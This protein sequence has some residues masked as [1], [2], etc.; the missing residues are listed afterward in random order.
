MWLGRTVRLIVLL[1]PIAAGHA[2]GVEPKIVIASDAIAPEDRGMLDEGIERTRN[3][4]SQ[5]GIF[6]RSDLYLHLASEVTAPRTPMIGRYDAA[7]SRVDL[8][9]FDSIR[10]RGEI[11]RTPW[12]ESLYI[13]FVVHELAHGF[14]DQHFGQD[15]ATLLAHEYLA[16]VAQLSSLPKG[17]RGDILRRYGLQGFQ[18]PKA[19]S[20]LY[21]QL[22]PCAFGVKAYLHFD[23]QRDKRGFLQHLLDGRTPLSVDTQEWW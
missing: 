16:Y 11:F 12:D 8:L 20:V 15:A 17:Q 2:N 19:M 13:S 3:F 14:A 18:N 22:D 7:R 4:F 5:Y 21:Y 23:A 1:T 9:T 10:D 6:L